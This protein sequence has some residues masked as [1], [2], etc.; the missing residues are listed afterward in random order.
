MSAANGGSAS[1]YLS[2]TLSGLTSTSGRKLVMAWMYLDSA[3]SR[4]NFEYVWDL[5][6][7]SSGGNPA[8]E[9][10][11]LSTTAARFSFDATSVDSA[12]G[13]SE[14]TWHHVAMSYGPWNDGSQTRRLWL[15]GTIGSA[16]LSLGTTGD[17]DYLRLMYALNGGTRYIRG[18]IAEVAIF[19]G[20]TTG[21]EDTAV[22]DAQTKTITNLAHTP[23]FGWRLLSGGTADYG[24]V[25][26]TETGTITWSAGTHP[27]LT[28]PGGGGSSS[29]AQI[30]IC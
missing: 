8:M 10:R 27:T 23:D 5:A 1:N 18:N 9:C 25:N 12:A 7:G 22:S 4:N 30:I 3:Y 21:Q 24:G 19:D 11:A 14:D 17:L 20:L 13:L 6:N 28:G 2:A 16:S 15:D 29:R 26:L